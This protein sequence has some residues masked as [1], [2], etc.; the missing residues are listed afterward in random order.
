MPDDLVIMDN[1]PAHKVAGARDAIE[2][3][4]A[5]LLYLPPYS[6]DLNP[7]E[8]LFAKLKALLRQ[9]A[10]RNIPRMPIAS[11]I[12]SA[13]VGRSSRCAFSFA[14][15]SWHQPCRV[16]GSWTILHVLGGWKLRQI[17][18]RCCP[19]GLS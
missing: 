11:P 2:A 15:K 17:S 10:G 18:Q 1:L 12:S 8:M 4:G 7:I 9:A 5:I 14:A 3:A 16:T 19:L 6:L 13:Q